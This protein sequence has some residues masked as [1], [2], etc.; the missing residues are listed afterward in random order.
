M[1]LF[2]L[3]VRLIIKYSVPIIPSNLTPSVLHLFDKCKDT[4]PKIPQK[5][6]IQYVSKP[7]MIVRLSK[8]LA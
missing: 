6:R 4:F 7:I 8:Y 3:D 1:K 5:T 2:C